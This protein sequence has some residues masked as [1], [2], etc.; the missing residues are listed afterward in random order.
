MDVHC[1]APHRRL[2]PDPTRVTQS[3]KDQGS[4][5][6]DPLLPCSLGVDDVRAPD[7]RIHV[8][9]YLEGQEFLY[10]LVRALSG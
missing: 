8:Q 10:R 6:G 9:S 3:S 1:A 2:S 5:G 4:R 7:E